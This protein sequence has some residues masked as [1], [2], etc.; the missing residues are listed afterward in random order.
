[1]EKCENDGVASHDYCSGAAAV[2][3]A[4]EIARQLLHRTK[5]DPAKGTKTDL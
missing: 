2:E 5:A 3:L 4:E 1:V